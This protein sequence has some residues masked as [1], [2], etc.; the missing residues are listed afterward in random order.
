MS[1]TIHE[2]FLYRYTLLALG[3]VVETVLAALGQS[4][5]DAVR[6]RCGPPEPEWA[7]EHRDADEE[8]RLMVALS[9]A[10]LH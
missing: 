1:T 4:W 3:R 8:L 9:C 2:S 5:L 7:P 10:G 6:F